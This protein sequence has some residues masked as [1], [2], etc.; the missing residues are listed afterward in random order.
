MKR[1]FVLCALLSVVV[2]TGCA[3]TGRTATQPNARTPAKSPSTTDLLLRQQVE[4]EG[5]G[6]G[7]WV[8][9]AGVCARGGAGA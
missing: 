6:G 7:F 4:C 1:S 3:S 2:A 8:A 9:A 5:R